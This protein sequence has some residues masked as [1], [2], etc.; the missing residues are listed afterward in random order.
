MQKYKRVINVE[1]S[2]LKE[3]LVI[4]LIVLYLLSDGGGDRTFVDIV[5][6]LDRTLGEHLDSTYI[7][8]GHLNSEFRWII[9]IKFLQE[10]SRCYNFISFKEMNAI[11]EKYQYNDLHNLRVYIRSMSTFEGDIDFDDF[12]KF[13]KILMFL[14]D[15]K[16]NAL[17]ISNKTWERIETSLF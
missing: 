3:R 15:C 11:L 17:Y 9:L 10:N 1:G 6:Q 8:D 2:S 14:F 13:A 12:R 4:F 5:K 7:S 16:K